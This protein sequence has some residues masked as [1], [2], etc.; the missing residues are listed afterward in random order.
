MCA[1]GIS[2]LVGHGSCSLSGCLVPGA[3]TYQRSSRYGNGAKVLRTVHSSL[4]HVV[5]NAAG[6]SHV[7]EEASEAMDKDDNVDAQS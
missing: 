2:C 1:T 6:D 4:R 3:A 5:G 7:S